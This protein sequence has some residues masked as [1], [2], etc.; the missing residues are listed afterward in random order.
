MYISEKMAPRRLGWDIT[1]N[2]GVNEKDLMEE[3]Y[4]F[5]N[6]SENELLQIIVKRR[7]HKLKLIE[8]GILGIRNN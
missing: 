5:F 3:W 7:Q 6:Q 4:R 1:P 8:A 2:D